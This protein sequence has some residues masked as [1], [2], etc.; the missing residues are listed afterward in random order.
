MGAG[1]DFAA[2]IVDAANMNHIGPGKTRGLYPPRLHAQERHRQKEN[3]KKKTAH[4]KDYLSFSPDFNCSSIAKG[5]SP[6]C[7]GRASKL[8]GFFSNLSLRSSLPRG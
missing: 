4:F 1:G 5:D 2:L 8:T 3:R 6:T 7:F